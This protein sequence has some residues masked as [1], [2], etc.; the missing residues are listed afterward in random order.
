[1]KESTC[2]VQN[3]WCQIFQIKSDEG[4]S[5]KDV[6]SGGREGGM[7]N[8]KLGRLSRLKWGDREREGVKNFE[9]WGDVF[10]GWSLIH[11]MSIHEWKK[12]VKCEICGVEYA[13]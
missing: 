10:Y 3:L 7:K 8:C 6:S 9:K 2:Q 1:M 11:I 5:I 13:K 4:P 12:P